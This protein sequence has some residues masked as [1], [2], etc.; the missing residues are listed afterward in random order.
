MRRRRSSVR[1]ADGAGRPPIPA[2]TSLDGARGHIDDRGTAAGAAAAPA[3][4]PSRGDRVSKLLSLLCALFLSG[5]ALCQDVGQLVAELLRAKDDAEPALIQ[6]IVDTRDRA[7]CEGLIKAYEAVGSIFTKREVLRALVSFAAVPET[8]QPALTKLA[9]IAGAAE[10]AELRDA[11]I[12]GLSQSG[13]AGKHFLRQL[14]ASEANDVVRL[15][16]L[17]EHVKQATPGDAEWYRALWNLKGEQRKD[18]NGNI[19]APEL[20]QVRELAFQ[21]LLAVLTEEEFLETLRRETATK[22]RRMA[23]NEMHRRDFPKTSETAT[24]VLSRVDFTGADRAEAARILIARDGAKAATQFFELAKKRDVTQEDLRLEMAR[25]VVDLNDDATNKKFAKLIGKGKPHERVFVMKAS[26]KVIDT[27]V[28]AAIR[29]E[30]LAAELE[31]RRAAAETLVARDDRESVPDL[32]AMLAK[33]KNPGDARLAIEAISKLDRSSAWRAELAQLCANA[34]R[35][36][37]NTALEQIGEAGDKKQ[38]PV[39]LTALEHEDWSTRNLAVASLAKVRDK[40]AVPK[41]I[42][43]M[44]KEPG[45]MSKACAEVLWSLTAMPFEEDV[46]RWKA[47]WAEAGAKFELATAKDVEKAEHARAE[48]RLRE[49]TRATAQFFGIKVESHRVIFVIDTSGSMIESMYGRFVGKRGAARIDIAKQELMQAI[50]NLDASALF[51]VYAFNSGVEKWKKDSTGT[52]SEASKKEAIEWV[53][54]L[55]AAGATNLYDSVKQAF[56]DK[57]VDTIFIMSDGEPTNGE[58]IDPHR[59]REDVAFWNKHR[60]IKINTIAIGGTLEVLEWLAKDAGGL[61]V[62]MR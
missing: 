6:K 30:L 26:E 54:R 15:P 55:G 17:R 20:N 57:D 36:V 22:I 48:K 51:N 28:L 45:R 35:D 18:K 23:L 38:L 19:Q 59:I 13:E 60:K 61:Y 12:V 50:K 9:N 4:R 34:D 33:A 39:I 8:Q 53:E 56:E 62:Q 25:L 5:G 40:Q 3:R 58:V 2:P 32:K 11:A 37:R 21:G 27:K 44:E 10:D 24:W 52:N 47:W 1:S 7:G 16:A 46:T 14:V 43:R 31:V 29:K 49:R 42:E 41:L